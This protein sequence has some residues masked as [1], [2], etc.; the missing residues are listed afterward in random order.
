MSIIA[1]TVTAYNLHD[2]RAQMEVAE[3]F[4][5]RIHIDLM[6][7]IFAPTVSP[8]LHAIWLPENIDCDVHLMFQH[9][10][11]QLKRLLA[12]NPKKIIIQAEAQKDSVERFISGIRQTKVGLGI[13]LLADTSPDEPHIK[14][15]I[16]RCEYVLIF[17]G[18]LGYHGGE[19]DLALL[20]KITKIKHINSNVEIGWD[21]GINADNIRTLA[22]KGVDVLNVGG[23]I[24]KQKDPESAYIELSKLLA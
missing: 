15:W 18:H 7:G 12:L 13:S 4:A 22:D 11:Q 19:A 17:S 2:Y 10:Y 1:P 24:Q 8:S 23:A 5:R 21:G 14:N 9:P 3:K 20:E 6:D 16:K